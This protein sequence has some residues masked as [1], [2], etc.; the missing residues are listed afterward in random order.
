MHTESTR[1]VYTTIY[2]TIRKQNVVDYNYDGIS[3]T[4]A[5]HNI[6]FLEY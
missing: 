3:I 6:I 4:D 5:I 1:K 2:T